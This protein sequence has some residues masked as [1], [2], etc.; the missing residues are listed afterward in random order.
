ML[1]RSYVSIVLVG[2]L[3][4]SSLSA[5]DLKLSPDGWAD[6]RP[7]IQGSRVTTAI[8]D[9][10]H[11]VLVFGGRPKSEVVILNDRFSETNR[12]Q[13]EGYQIL[14]SF[15]RGD[16]ILGRIINGESITF[17][18]CPYSLNGKN[19]NSCATGRGSM[20]KVVAV[21][22]SLF[23]L[24]YGRIRAIDFTTGSSVSLSEETLDADSPTVATAIGSR[25]VQVSML[26]GKA[27]IWEPGSAVRN[28][29]LQW[30]GRTAA[31]QSRRKNQA[32][33][34]NLVSWDERELWLTPAAYN[35]F[36][37]HP[38]ERFHM[39]GSYIGRIILKLPA[40]EELKRNPQSPYEPSNRTGHVFAGF[41]LPMGSRIVAIDPVAGRI[42]W[43]SLPTLSKQ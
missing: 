29:D 41:L 30:P 1:K 40:F 16:L 21:G 11:L 23:S 8:S 36:E 10:Q 13:A 32:V 33:V 38:L 2:Q 22:A 34:S 6:V 20:E 37:G 7:S 4:C 43:F 5:N 14:S 26:S 15:L 35:L 19:R 28:L 42:V 9:S 24:T 3:L 27:T 18:L 31:L 12:W 25:I 17:Q 39:D